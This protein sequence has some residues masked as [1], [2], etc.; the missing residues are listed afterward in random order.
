MNI[1]QSSAQEKLFLSLNDQKT[2]TSSNLFLILS[3]RFEI[4][5]EIKDSIFLNFEKIK[6]FESLC[7]CIDDEEIKNLR[8]GNNLLNSNL[9]TS[10]EKGEIIYEENN[11]F[12]EI[13]TLT[14]KIEKSYSEPDVRKEINLYEK[15]LS[16]LKNLLN[17]IR[18]SKEKYGDNMKSVTKISKEKKSIE[19][20]LLFQNIVYSYLFNVPEGIW[21]KLISIYNFF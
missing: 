6:L 17:N 11:S 12:E 7:K 8:M 2:K 14:K 21:G 18:K 20:I 5:M 15:D 3:H 19:V 13:E 9:E 10:L 4:Q 1:K 16:E